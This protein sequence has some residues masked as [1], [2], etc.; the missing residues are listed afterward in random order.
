MSATNRHPLIGDGS[1]I[2]DSHPLVLVDREAEPYRWRCGERAHTDWDRTNSH[3]WCRGCLRQHE[4]GDD[5]VDPEHYEVWDA[6][7]DR[8]VPWSAV[9]TPA[10]LAVTERSELEA[11]YGAAAADELLGAIENE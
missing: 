9:V 2:Q 11:A 8:L 3:I 6:K 7:E 1:A 10:D 4:A 5:D